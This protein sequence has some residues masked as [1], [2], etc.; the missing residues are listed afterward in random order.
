MVSR[1]GTPTTWEV[2]EAG[3]DPVRPFAISSKSNLRARIA[4]P[5]NAVPPLCVVVQKGFTPLHI[6]C[7]Y[8]R[9]SVVRQLLDKD[10]DA[11]VQGRNG[12]T[13]LHV[14]THYG[15]PTVVSVLLDGGASP[16]HT[17]KVGAAPSPVC[18]SVCSPP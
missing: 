11:D 13:P 15:H 4:P 17:A 12:L 7:K 1:V 10:A 18:R 3:R 14:A 6:A 9:G 5:L 2:S 8:G 16:H